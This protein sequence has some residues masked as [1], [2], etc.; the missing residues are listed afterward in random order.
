MSFYMLNTILPHKWMGTIVKVPFCF[1]YQ[2]SEGLVWR[3]LLVHVDGASFFLIYLFSP[4][5][6]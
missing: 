4:L 6:L 1:E 3:S 5:E 2:N